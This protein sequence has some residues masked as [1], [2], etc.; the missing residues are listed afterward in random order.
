VIVPLSFN[1]IK[2]KIRSLALDVIAWFSNIIPEVL[3]KTVGIQL[4]FFGQLREN[5][6]FNHTE[7]LWNAVDDFLVEDVHACIDFVTDELFWFLYKFSD[8]I[9]IMC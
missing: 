1:V 2:L 3:F 5:L 4:T 9:L 7:S 8:F 6:L